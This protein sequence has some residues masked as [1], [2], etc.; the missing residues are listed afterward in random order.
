MKRK[1]NKN[2]NKNKNSNKNKNKNKNKYKK[3]LKFNLKCQKINQQ[4]QIIIQLSFK[5]II[6]V[7]IK[8][9]NK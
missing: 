7:I 5:I 1:N 6:L 2:K 8:H 9:Y 3:N 4:N